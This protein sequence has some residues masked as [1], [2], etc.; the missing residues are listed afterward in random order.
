MR[1]SDW[2]SDVCSSDLHERLLRRWPR[3]NHRYRN[4]AGQSHRR[5]GNADIA[6][7]ERPPPDHAPGQLRARI[8]G[9]AARISVEPARRAGVIRH[10]APD[11]FRLRLP[12][13]LLPDDPELPG[14]DD[15]VAGSSVDRSVG[16]ECVRPYTSQWSTNLQNNQTYIFT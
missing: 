5:S 4:A 7:A 14:C 2:S 6:A 10:A 8:A 1:I 9:P 15:H 3:R 11:G 16:N 12:G 13:V